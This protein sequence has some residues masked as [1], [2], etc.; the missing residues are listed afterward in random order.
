VTYARD[1]EQRASEG[2]YTIEAEFFTENFVIWGAITGPDAR[3]SDH[4]NGTSS[5]IE[6]RPF[7]VEQIATRRI[8]ELPGAFAHLNKSE[9]LFVLPI[10][11]PTE[12]SGQ[13]QVAWE[14]KPTQRCW[15]AAG[16]YYLAGNVLSDVGRDPRQVLRSLEQKV[17]LPVM[18]AAINFPDGSTRDYP[19]V[20]VNRLHVELLSVMS[21]T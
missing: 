4:L 13:S 19:A 18:S 2:I 7:Q 1:M 15:V 14:W 21:A 20:I 6:I 12:A 9:L 17:F 16:R 10:K 3:I 11:E 5:F 8:I